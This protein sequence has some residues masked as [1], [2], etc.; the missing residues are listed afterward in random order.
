M[1]SIELAKA[2]IGY[3]PKVLFADGLRRTIDWY[4]KQ[5]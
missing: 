5:R 1:A 3:E 2:L 4:K